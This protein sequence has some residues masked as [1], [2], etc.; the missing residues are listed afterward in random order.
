ML[1]I[2]PLF[3]GAITGVI[4]AYAYKRCHYLIPNII[5]GIIGAFILRFIAYWILLDK[6][7]RPENNFSLTGIASSLTGA[8]IATFITKLL[9]PVTPMGTENKDH[10]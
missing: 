9:P 8:F 2:T 3:I 1:L 5:Y 4:M 7:A 6:T 10:K